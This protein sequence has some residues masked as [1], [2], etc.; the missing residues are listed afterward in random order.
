VGYLGITAAAEYLIIHRPVFSLSAKAGIV[1]NSLVYRK[2]LLL[3]NTGDS[4]GIDFADMTF[5]S[6]VFGLMVGVAGG[7]RLNDDLQLRLD[8]GYRFYTTDV[9]SYPD[10]NSQ[11]SAV[12][13]SVG[14]RYY[15]K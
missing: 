4:S 9:F 8:A 13:L 5:A 1:V 10:F 15:L 2:G 3:E 14:I 11:L 12:G 7:F 6:P